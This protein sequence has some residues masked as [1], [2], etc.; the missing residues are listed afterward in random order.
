MCHL[1]C[2]IADMT[3]VII[4]IIALLATI[5][6]SMMRAVVVCVTIVMKMKI[7]RMII[8]NYLYLNIVDI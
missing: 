2:T 5:G 6:P 3:K 1:K 8:K 4:T 7:V